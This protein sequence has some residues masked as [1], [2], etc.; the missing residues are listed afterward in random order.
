M[1]STDFR[2]SRFGGKG[3]FASARRKVIHRR[4][5]RAFGG[6]PRRRLNNF[7][8]DTR[9]SLC[10]FGGPACYALKD[11]DRWISWSAI[12]RGERLKLVVQNRRF[13]L[14]NDLH[15]LAKRL[16]KK[17]RQAVESELN[18]LES[19]RQRMDYA[20]ARRAG[21]P[22]GAATWN[23]RADNTNVGSNAPA[24]SG[25]AWGMKG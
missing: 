8:A 14:L 18:Y 25:A 1:T 19:H 2:W 24:S 3:F 13:L 23:Q 7:G 5:R 11:R 16:R 9:S 21:G 4:L 6:S 17:K 12:Q 20:V 15:T 10:W 22:Q